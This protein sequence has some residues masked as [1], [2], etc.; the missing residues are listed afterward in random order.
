[1]LRRA[2]RAD[3]TV[4]FSLTASTA[5]NAATP[6]AATTAESCIESPPLV[7]F[8]SAHVTSRCTS[9]KF[10]G[11]AD[12]REGSKERRQEENAERERME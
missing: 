4:L 6:P 3:S 11:V 7:R 8:L 1:M 12:E 10:Y 5:V 2:L 9:R